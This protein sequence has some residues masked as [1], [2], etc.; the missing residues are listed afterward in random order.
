MPTTR[1]SWLPTRPSPKSPKNPTRMSSIHTPLTL[2]VGHCPI[3]TRSC[4]VWQWSDPNAPVA[5]EAPA[6]A[7]ASSPA[8][9]AA[10][11]ARAA[12]GA[13]SGG[14]GG[15][16]KGRGSGGREERYYRDGEEGSQAAVAA[17][18]DAQVRFLCRGRVSRVYVTVGNG[19]VVG[20]WAPGQW[21]G[22]CRV[23]LPR[24]AVGWYATR[25]SCSEG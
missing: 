11:F 6:G 19:G 15:S 25:C 13:A 22:E 24:V 18:T 9:L 2:T 16:A 8:A 14:A 23:V 12:S 4:S 5:G 7:L 17:L 21:G 3:C 1:A 10:A 20:A